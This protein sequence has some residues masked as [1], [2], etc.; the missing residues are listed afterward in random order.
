LK[1]GRVDKLL[2]RKSGNSEAENGGSGEGNTGK[3]EGKSL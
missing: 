1:A 2:Q 3:D